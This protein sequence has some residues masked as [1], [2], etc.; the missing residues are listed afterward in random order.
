MTARDAVRRVGVLVAVLAALGLL[1]ALGV[2]WLRRGAE[3]A[4]MPPPPPPPP[5]GVVVLSPTA[6]ANAGVVVAPAATTVWVERLQ[7]PGVLALD[8]TRT[9][10]IGSLVDGTAVEVS[11]Q[12]GDRV[13]A[14]QALALLHSP[15]VHEAWAAYRK[16]IAERKR[17]TT[18]LS[19]AV[20]AAERVRR[21]YADK[22]ASLQEVQKADVDRGA[23]EQ[24]LDMAK[25]EVRRSEEVLEHY[26]ITSGEDPT[27]ES[28]EQIPVRSP[29][30]AA[31][32]ERQVTTGTA[33]TSGM[34]LFV[35]SD[36]STL[37]A[38]AEVD[39]TALP[40]VKVGMPV[41]IR[42]AA[43]PDEPFGGSIIFV[44]DTLDPKT[45]RVS[46]RCT[47]PNADG[48][49]KPQMYATLLLE[50]G[51]QRTVL[52]VPTAAVQELDG[53][54]VVFV[55]DR[56][57]T[58]RRRDVVLGRVVDDAVEIVSGLQAGEPIAVAG[59]F[60]LKSELLKAFAPED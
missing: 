55:T 11:V 26:G 38:L 40:R 48:R 49:L 43:Y 54:S 18:D 60:V 33:V 9:A 21:L 19:Y 2:T 39:E 59:S 34:P 24:G 1:V 29:L 56:G 32:L 22:A 28:G 6:Q 3:V 57:G 17:A 37:W 42:V 51:A 23:A 12:V 7:A 10:R 35:V 8:E 53:T 46:V 5:D 30:A 41:E 31:V 13:E 44:G 36:L 52:S 4:T 50:E 16:A 14:G 45:R 15:I 20:Q 27:G 47:V 25:T 58:F